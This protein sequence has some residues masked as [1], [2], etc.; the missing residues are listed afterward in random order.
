MTENQVAIMPISG[1]IR[2]MGVRGGWVTIHTG[3]DFFFPSDA[4]LIMFK[5]K[6]MHA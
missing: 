4:V 6:W 2:G 1:N 3:M 5:M